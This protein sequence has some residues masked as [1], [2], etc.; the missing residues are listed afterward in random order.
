MNDQDRELVERIVSAVGEA[1]KHGYEALVRY[2]VVDGIVSA[3]CFAIA[4]AGCAW[5]FR[6]LLA[7][8]PGDGW[9]AEMSHVARGAGFVVS[10]VAMFL[11][12]VGLASNIVQ[13]IQPEGSVIKLAIAK[14]KN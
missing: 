3:I 13:A 5:C 11:M 14:A 12:L 4:L 7:W 10:A 9:D 2:Q 8:K 1:G 6:K